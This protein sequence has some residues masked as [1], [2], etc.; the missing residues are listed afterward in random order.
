MA[1]FSSTLAYVVNKKGYRFTNICIWGKYNDIFLLE[2]MNK[3]GGCS[4][5]IIAIGMRCIYL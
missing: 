4:E 2:L 1:C 3:M 5:N